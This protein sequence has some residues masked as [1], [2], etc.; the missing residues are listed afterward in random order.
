MTNVTETSRRG[1]PTGPIDLDVSDGSGGGNGAVHSPAPASRGTA[2]TTAQRG[3]TERGAVGAGMAVIAAAALAWIALSWI[4]GDRPGGLA[5][6]A[7]VVTATALIL[8]GLHGL[9][10][11]R[12]RRVGRAR[13]GALALCLYLVAVIGVSVYATQ[14][15]AGDVLHAGP[16]DDQ[17]TLEVPS[18]LPVATAG[19]IRLGDVVAG[20]DRSEDVGLGLTMA[21]LAVFSIGIPLAFLSEDGRR[22]PRASR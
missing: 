22:R 13:G 18:L 2:T 5:A 12:S 16:A 8:L 19:E 15:A 17:V 20:V 4:P 1:T 14:L 9:H 6:P 11:L 3:S 21:T 10:G 7:G